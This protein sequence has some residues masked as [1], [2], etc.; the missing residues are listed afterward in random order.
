MRSAGRSRAIA[1]D[2]ATLNGDIVNLIAD[3]TGPTG[4]GGTATLETSGGTVDIGTATL[5]A[6][7]ST[8]GGIVNVR[9]IASFYS[10][11]T[12]LTLDSLTATANGGTT[13]GQI[14]IQVR[15]DASADLGVASLTALGT[16]ARID[17]EL[18]SVEFE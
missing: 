16:D 5:S 15:G 18:G 14:E 10:T 3:A 4:S 8:D 12:L 7:G 17:V 6:N 11:S 13:G 1:Y 2:G 9:S